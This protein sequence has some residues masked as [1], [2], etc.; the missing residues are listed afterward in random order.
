MVVYASGFVV[1]GAGTQK[2][3]GAEILKSLKN[4]INKHEIKLNL[5]A[6]TRIEIEEYFKD[7]VNKLKLDKELGKY[8]NILCT[9]DKKSHFKEFNE[10]LHTT[11]I[12][13]TKPSELSFY[14]AL[15]I[16]II[17]A[18]AL[19]THET[20][21]EKWLNQ[22]GTGFKQEDPRYTDEWLFDWIN[23]GMLA[24]AALEGY[25]EAPKYGT[26]NIEKVIF[27]RTKRNIK[28]RY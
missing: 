18:Y 7:T 16:P 3:I 24:E 8:I 21:N 4:K 9:L 25:I 2:E 10:L 5:I 27:S 11:D 26:Y 15:G 6:G 12:L 13:W 17:V 19:G 28:F 14:T 20:L 23:K 22:M 1:G